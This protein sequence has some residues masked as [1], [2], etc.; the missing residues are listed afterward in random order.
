[1][2]LGNFGL[3]SLYRQAVYMVQNDVPHHLPVPGL[4]PAAVPMR[5]DIDTGGEDS[6][7]HQAPDL[8]LAV[9]ERP[10]PCLMPPFRTP[11]VHSSG[12]GRPAA[13]TWM[14]SVVPAFVP[15]VN[16]TDARSQ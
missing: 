7:S 2:H 4:A 9:N 14:A 3:E 12:Q 13:V 11:T 15:Q 5:A 1:M 8:V 10:V 16:A 6:A